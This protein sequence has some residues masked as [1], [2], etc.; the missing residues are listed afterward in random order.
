MEAKKD[1]RRCVLEI[2][3]SLTKKEWEEKSLVIYDKL[4][5]HPFFLE[6][7]EIYCYIDFRNEV[8][9]K[10]IIET[11]WDMN[12]KV[13]VPKTEEKQM[14]FYYIHS[15][16]ELEEGRWGILEPKNG[17]LAEGKNVCVVLPGSVFDKN[18]NR[19]GYGRGY[20]DSY[21]EQHADYKKIAIAFELQILDEIPTEMHDVKPQCIITEETIYA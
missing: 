15:W 21:L 4:I 20:Y 19:I 2:R 13:A 6:S 3:N 16:E 5:S 8:G 18:R 11:A 10:K 14:N 7:E 17:Q 1:I 12:K 9:T